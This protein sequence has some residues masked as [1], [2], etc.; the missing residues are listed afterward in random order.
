[1]PLPTIEGEKVGFA[2]PANSP[3]AGTSAQMHESAPS[4]GMALRP[5][6]YTLVQSY[7]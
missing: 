5:G 3:G 6:V 7:G 4:T 1:M 2:V